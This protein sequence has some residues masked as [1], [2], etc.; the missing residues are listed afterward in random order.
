M[1]AGTSSGAVPKSTFGL[2]LDLGEVRPRLYQRNE[3]Y[4]ICGATE[5]LADG[6]GGQ[7][8]GVNVS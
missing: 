5:E 2:L 1:P 4:Q 7:S 6:E 8:V 3:S